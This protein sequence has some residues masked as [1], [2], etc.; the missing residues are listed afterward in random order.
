MTLDETKEK[1]ESFKALEK[2][3]HFGEGIPAKPETAGAALSLLYLAARK[4]FDNFDA[5]PGVD[6]SVMLSIYKNGYNFECDFDSENSGTIWI[7][8]YL[9]SEGVLL[10]FVEHHYSENNSFAEILE[11][12]D[13]F[14]TLYGYDKLV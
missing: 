1:I 9:D 3:W 6:G 5:F 4:G 2:G 11:K 14:K 7:E 13:A 10:V 12:L 8:Q